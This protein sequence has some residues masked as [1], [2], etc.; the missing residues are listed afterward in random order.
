MRYVFKILILGESEGALEYVTRALQD[1]GE[2]KE[3]YNEWYKE[4]IAR[5]HV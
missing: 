5:A 3:T 4:K 2:N 1:M